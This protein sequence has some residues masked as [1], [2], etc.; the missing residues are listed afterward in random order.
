[1]TGTVPAGG[2]TAAFLVFDDA[3]YITGTTLEI[4]GG[5]VLNLVRY[6]PRKG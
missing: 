6:D 2:K 4:D 1:M 3:G 5:Y